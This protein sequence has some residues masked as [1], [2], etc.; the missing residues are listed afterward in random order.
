ML[1]AVV[2][3]KDFRVQL[4]DCPFAGGYSIGIGND[5]GDSEEVFGE[6]KRFISG[7]SFAG[8]KFDPI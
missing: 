8:Q 7:V 2:E 1:K 3:H 6:E 4:L 5:C